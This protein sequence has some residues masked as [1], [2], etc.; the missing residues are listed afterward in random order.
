MRLYR[1]PAACMRRSSG[2]TRVRASSRT[3]TTR[4]SALG[5]TMDH[6][7]AASHFFPSTG[8]SSARKCALSVAFG[9]GHMTS[10]CFER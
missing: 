3:S 10:A 6:Q 2:M 4:H 1:F 7:H 8:P 5:H 9:Y